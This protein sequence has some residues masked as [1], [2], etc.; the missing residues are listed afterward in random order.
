MYILHVVL[1]KKSKTSTAIR[2][3]Y[4]HHSRTLFWSH[5]RSVYHIGLHNLNYRVAQGIVNMNFELLPQM[6]PKI[7]VKFPNTW[8]KIIWKRKNIIVYLL[9]PIFQFLKNGIVCWNIAGVFLT[10]LLLVGFVGFFFKLSAL[11]QVKSTWAIHRLIFPLLPPLMSCSSA[12][13]QGNTHCYNE[14]EF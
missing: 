10:Q 5:S 1:W 6:R 9:F 7:S 14:L 8:Q 11:F 3:I 12:F 2:P 13:L 4:K